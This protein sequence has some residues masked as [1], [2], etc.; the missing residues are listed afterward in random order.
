MEYP[1]VAVTILA[2]RSK[3][4]IRPCIDSVL[5]QDYR[6]EIVVRVREQAGDNEEYAILE[7]IAQRAGERPEP[8]SRLRGAVRDSP[9]PS[10]S[11][12][13][14]V[15]GRR[16]IF[17]SRGENLG[18][19]A[20]HN[21]LIR[22]S[23]N[24][25]VLCLNADAT[26]AQD[27]LSRT[28]PFF[29]N[30]MMGAVQ[31]KLLRWDAQSGKLLYGPRQLPVLDTTG[32]KPLRNRRIVNRGQGEEDR[33]QYDTAA[34]RDTRDDKSRSRGEVA[35]EIFGADGAA[36]LYRKAA[37][38]DVA[39][40]F[41]AFRKG[42]SDGDRIAEPGSRGEAAGQFREYF[43]ED[44]FMY[45]EDVDLAWRFQWRGW[46]TLYVPEA[47]AWHARGSG[48]SAAHSAISIIR[49]RRKLSPSAKYY[50]FANQRLMQVKNETC[51]G[52]LR[53]FLPWYVKEA[54]AWWFA[55]LTERKTVPAIFRIVRLLPK[56]RKKRRWIMAHRK[57]SANPYRWFV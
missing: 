26:L 25:F 16:R 51:R 6:G 30:P 4:T 28:I 15:Q 36:P 14:L 9:E 34:P 29:A 37:L 39:I 8:E 57:P 31:G 52:L 2:Y 22:E 43:D 33:K 24:D 3:E 7:N 35:G 10:P 40:P 13:N 42:R 18:F 56:M 49:E 1:G 38:E 21:A 48:D 44:F 50:A 46:L 47:V 55:L 17:I 20:G 32:L 45:K 23:E 53:D 41:S 5:H 19:A 54:G 12:R 27:F 11:R